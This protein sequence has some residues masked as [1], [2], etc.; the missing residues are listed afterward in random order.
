MYVDEPLLSRSTIVRCDT[1]VLRDPAY[2]TAVHAPVRGTSLNELYNGSHTSQGH[3]S[4]V[5]CDLLLRR[6]INLRVEAEN[7][8]GKTFQPLVLA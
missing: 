7:S 5:V 1:L 3:R 6:E 4:S 2:G 8:Q